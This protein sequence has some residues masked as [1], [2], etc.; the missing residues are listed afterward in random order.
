EAEL[1]PAHVG[2]VRQPL[3]LQLQRRLVGTVALD[4]QVHDLELAAAVQDASER[5]VIRDADPERDGVSHQ[6]QGRD[7]TARTR[8]DFPSP[9][10]L[11]VDGGSKALPVEAGP[12]PRLPTV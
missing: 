9:V 1:P 11:L 6:D 8:G 7:L 4:P 10:A 5:L 3:P 2:L 12:G